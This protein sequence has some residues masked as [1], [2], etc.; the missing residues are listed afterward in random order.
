MQVI[1]TQLT[2]LD[3]VLPHE[4]QTENIGGSAG[5]QK[6]FPLRAAMTLSR[7]GVKSYSYLKMSLS[8]TAVTQVQWRLVENV[9]HI[10]LKKIDA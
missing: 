10:A 8:S 6:T 9:L 7:M 2:T 1:K 4:K 3:A 5:T